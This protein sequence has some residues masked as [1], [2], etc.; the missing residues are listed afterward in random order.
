MWDGDGGW[1]SDIHFSGKMIKTICECDEGVRFSAYVRHTYIHIHILMEDST[2][3]AHKC[4]IFNVFVRQIVKYII[5]NL[6]ATSDGIKACLLFPT[7]MVRLHSCVCVSLCVYTIHVCIVYVRVSQVNH[8]KLALKQHYN[9]IWAIQIYTL[10]LYTLYALYVVTYAKANMK[11]NLC[12]RNDCL[13]SF[14]SGIAMARMF[15]SLCK[16]ERKRIV[17]ERENENAHDS[18]ANG[19]WQ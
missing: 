17:G 3:R 18:L 10:M 14:H 4:L 15:R 7:F 16:K 12:S 9:R 5:C 11:T 8:I 1:T 6:E 19:K 13:S 2:Q